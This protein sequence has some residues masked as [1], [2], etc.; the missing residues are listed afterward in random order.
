MHCY[1]L[2]ASARHTPHHCS[3][4]HRPGQCLSLQPSQ[5]AWH[6]RQSNPMFSFLMWEAI[7][8]PNWYF[9][10]WGGEASRVVAIKPKGQNRPHQQTVI[11]RGR[12]SYRRLTTEYCGHDFLI[13]S[14]WFYMLTRTIRQHPAGDLL[15]KV[16]YG[17]SFPLGPCFRGLN[18]IHI[19]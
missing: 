2:K 17:V 8:K 5:W 11:S 3:V 7:S 16:R 19:L 9:L 6:W 14:R 12:L 15:C 10:V 1:Q 18:R 13:I 4:P